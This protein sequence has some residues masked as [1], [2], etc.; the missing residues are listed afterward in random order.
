MVFGIAIGFMGWGVWARHM[1]VSG[2]GP[3]SVFAFSMA[4]M[5]IAG[6]PV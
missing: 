4:T 3:I 6:R 1:F 2:I 5:F